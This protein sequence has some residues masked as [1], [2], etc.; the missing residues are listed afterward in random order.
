MA[1]VWGVPEALIP[2]PGLPAVQLLKSLG[3]D[4]PVLVAV[5]SCADEAFTRRLHEAGFDL[6]LADPADPV[7]VLQLLR[8]LAAWPAR[9]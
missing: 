2:G 4:R 6:R 7:E 5:A 8:V 3:K 9:D 1:G